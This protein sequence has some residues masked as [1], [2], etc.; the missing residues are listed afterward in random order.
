MR[1]GDCWLI[2]FPDCGPKAHLWFL[3]ADPQPGGESV[4]AS[5]TTL[6]HN[7]DQ[8]VILQPG[9]HAF[10][11]H[12]S[13]VLYSDCRIIAVAELAKL[14]ATGLALPQQPFAARVLAEIQSGAFVSDY[15]AR[16]VVNFLKA[17]GIGG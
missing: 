2:Q 4:I 5:L 8:T 14:A 1:A 12:P 17:A 6:R 9:D 3:L 16:K 7:A 10:I 15:T 11:R 13:F